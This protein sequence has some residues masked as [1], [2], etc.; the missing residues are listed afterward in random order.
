M[1]AGIVAPSGDRGKKGVL[2]MVCINL[3]Y[4][5]P[6]THAG[7]VITDP[8]GIVTPSGGRGKKG[9]LGMVCINLM[10]I[11]PYIHA[12]SVTVPPNGD[13][14]KKGVL[15]MVCINLMY[16]Y[17]YMHAGS[18]I[19]DPSGIVT[20]SGVPSGPNGKGFG[21]DR[22]KKGSFSMV[23]S[24]WIKLYDNN[25]RCLQVHGAFMQSS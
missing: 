2:G 9:V 15:G 11:Y 23:C 7:S 25:Y 10:Y 13:R 3:M 4:I 19:T 6:Y 5:Y 18:V 22:P 17:P 21:A 16:I 12:G 20:P 8:S 1:H 14:G 24:S